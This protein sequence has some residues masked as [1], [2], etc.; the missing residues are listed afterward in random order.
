MALY[1]QGKNGEAYFHHIEGIDGYERG[2]PLLVSL[3]AEQRTLTV[4]ARKHPEAAPFVLHGDEMLS[5]QTVSR[6]EKIGSTITDMIFGRPGIRFYFVIRYERDG[7]EKELVL[8]DH[9]S[10]HHM[11]LWK[12]SLKAM[13]R[14]RPEEEEN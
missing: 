1:A 5:F 3:N 2:W 9:S 6:R 10:T 13:M 11:D 8:Y 7:E 14:E 4:T 12:K